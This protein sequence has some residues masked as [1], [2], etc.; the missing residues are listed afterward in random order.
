[1]N[2][3][4]ASAECLHRMHSACTYEHCACRCHIDLEDETIDD[5]GF[6]LE[7]EL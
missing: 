3:N 5:Q 1:M 4:T 6:E 2:H 7:E